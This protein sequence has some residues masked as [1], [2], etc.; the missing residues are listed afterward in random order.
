[1]ELIC[2]WLI[3]GNNVGVVLS[4][5]DATTLQSILSLT[6]RCVCVWWIIIGLFTKIEKNTSNKNCYP[7]IMLTFIVL[8]VS[9]MSRNNMKTPDITENWNVWTQDR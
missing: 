7:L 6:D 5:S 1:M 2:C 3:I 9:E 8:V 4:W